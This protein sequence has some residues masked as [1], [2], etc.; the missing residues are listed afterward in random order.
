MNVR[1]QKLEQDFC[2]GA[3]RCICPCMKTLA[4]GGRRAGRGGAAVL[5][6]G[7]VL[8]ACQALPTKGPATATPPKATQETQQSK[9]LLFPVADAEGLL[10]RAVH[11]TGDGGWTIADARAAGCE[12]AVRR[13]KAEFQTRRQANLHDMTSVSAGFA[14]L[15]G[16][17]AQYGRSVTADIQIDNTEVLQA[18]TRGPCGELIVDQVFVGRG[19]RVLSLGSVVAG[20]AGV[21]I[22]YVTP[23]VAHSSESSTLDTTEW[24]SEQA[25]GFTARKTAGGEPLELSVNLPASVAEGEKVVIRIEASRKAYLIVYYLESDG[26]AALLWP[27]DEEPE[28]TA[29]P[30]QPATLPS[31]RER[32]AGVALQAALSKK[33][34]QAREMLVVYALTERGDYLRLK[35]APGSSDTNGAAYAAQLTQRIGD[36]PLSRWSRSLATYLITPNRK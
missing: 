29:G 10:G 31:E 33:G 1:R 19:K 35:P 5:V 24:K 11:A 34:E 12:V 20:K 30:G 28:P 25:Y 16:L 22:G 4:M 6:A 17:E 3:I 27:S 15:V 26:K 14:Q 21:T 8:G 32:A 23:G 18:D 13:S 2:A 9:L 36:I 7:A